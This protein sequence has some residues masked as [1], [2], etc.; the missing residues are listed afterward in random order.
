MITEV[1]GTNATHK[2]VLRMTI[3]MSGV[4]NIHW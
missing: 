1:I 2:N 4:S 3:T